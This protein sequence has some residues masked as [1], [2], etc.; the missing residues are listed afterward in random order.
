MES[1]LFNVLMYALLFIRGASPEFITADIHYFSSSMSMD[2]YGTVRV[3]NKKGAEKILLEFKEKEWDENKNEKAR[4]LLRFDEKKMFASGEGKTGDKKN[5]PIDIP[6]SP[7]KL[8]EEAYKGNNAGEPPKDVGKI[9]IADLNE[10]I[11]VLRFP[12]WGPGAYLILFKD[13]K[14]GLTPKIEL[15]GLQEKGFV[16]YRFEVSGLDFSK[17]D[18]TLFEMK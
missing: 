7:D 9:V 3:H 18:K 4:L 13:K 17:I 6:D 15:H 11:S 12:K 16:F 5:P 10:E 8:L 2:V 14:T 1:A